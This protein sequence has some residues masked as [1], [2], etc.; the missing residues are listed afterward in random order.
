MKGSNTRPPTGAEKLW[1]DLAALNCAD[2]TRR[3]R[4]E[5]VDGVYRLDHMRGVYTIDPAARTIEVPETHPPADE[6]LALLLL[7]YLVDLKER[8]PVGR[9]ISEKEIP[10]GS[11]FFTGPHALPLDPIAAAYGEAPAAFASRAAELGG[12]RL[13][14][15]D[16]SAAFD[17]LFRIPVAFVLWE[18]D[19]EFPAQATVMF[20]ETISTHLP[21]DVVL[22]LVRRTVKFLV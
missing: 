7:A 19:D 12:R 8:E 10:G 13:E 21:V 18:A 14:Y 17:A 5:F 22:A 11:L 4:A 3:T 9:W 15:G 1:R 20:D 2:V 16:A 6:E